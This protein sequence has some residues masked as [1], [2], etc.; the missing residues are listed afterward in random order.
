MNVNS[1]FIHHIVFLKAWDR[2][3]KCASYWVWPVLPW[4]QAQDSVT[5]RLFLYEQYIFLPVVIR[6]VPFASCPTILRAAFVSRAESGCKFQDPDGNQFRAS[7]NSLAEKSKRPCSSEEG[8]DKKLGQYLCGASGTCCCMCLRNYSA[9][10]QWGQP[11]I[12]V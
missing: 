2:W 3:V 5:I 12:T 11:R 7:I 6:S 10:Q 1:L 4:C 9:A 8:L